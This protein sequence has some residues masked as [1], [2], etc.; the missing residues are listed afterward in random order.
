M[1]KKLS[2]K[3]RKT[4]GVMILSVTLDWE[5]FSLLK[6]SIIQLKQT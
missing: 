5:H 4:L 3:M 6:T 1:S 2:P